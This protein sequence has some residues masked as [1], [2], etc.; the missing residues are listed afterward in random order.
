MSLNGRVLWSDG[1]RPALPALDGHTY[2]GFFV[3]YLI[4][5]ALFSITPLAPQPKTLK[6][7]RLFRLFSLT[8]PLSKEVG[9]FE[10]ATIDEFRV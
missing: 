8:C 3:G 2:Y 10:F 4:E 7:W 1:G 6:K 5:G 9:F